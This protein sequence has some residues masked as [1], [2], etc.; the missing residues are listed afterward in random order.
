MAKSITEAGEIKRLNK[1]FASIPKNKKATVEGLIVQAARLRVRLDD[2]WNDLKDGGEYELFSQSE[3]ADPYE[4]ERPASRIF[5]ATDKAYQS[6]IRQ[7][8]DLCP[9]D[10]V[11]DE[12]AEFLRDE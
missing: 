12:L 10:P 9:D 8:T 4:R 5:T 7:L 6:I 2:L 11:T 1:I 3:K